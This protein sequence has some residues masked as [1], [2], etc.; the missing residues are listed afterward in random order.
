MLS[1]KRARER[2][3]LLAALFGVVL[4]VCLTI[5]GLLGGIVG[6]ER[7]GI[8]TDLASRTGLDRMLEI[9]LPVVDDAD[10]QDVA[11]R[12]VIAQVFHRNGR[13]IPLAVERSVDEAEGVEVV[14]W[15][16]TPI[17]D[18]LEVRDLR[19]LAGG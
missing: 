6:A 12:E 15:T 8:R 11:V 18:A 7:E 3:S 9:S 13:A 2:V 4:L 1:L 16:I 5:A 10:T 19:A 14:S 17:V